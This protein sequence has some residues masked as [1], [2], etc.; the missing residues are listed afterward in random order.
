M[1]PD[2]NLWFTDINS[3]SIGRITTTGSVTHIAVPTPGQNDGITPGPDGNVW[4][5]ELS[6]SKVARVDLH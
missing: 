3:N 5:T 2:T 4:F 1:G 6:A